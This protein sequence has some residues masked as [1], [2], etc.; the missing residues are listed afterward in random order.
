MTSHVIHIFFY[1]LH[2]KHRSGAKLIIIGE[3]VNLL[4]HKINTLRHS[5]YHV[6]HS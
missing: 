3:V 1:K 6:E 2:A 4:T 5:F